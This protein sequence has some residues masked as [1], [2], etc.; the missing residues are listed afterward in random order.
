MRPLY[1]IL[2]LWCR[3]ASRLFF[4]DF[5]VIR[6]LK[7]LETAEEDDEDFGNNETSGAPTTN[8]SKDDLKRTSGPDDQQKQK[9]PN[10]AVGVGSGVSTDLRISGSGD[11][12]DE[13]L[14]NPELK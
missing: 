5:Q 2:S 12:A 14:E 8:Y 1:H 4:L 10:M 7:W 9:L 6:W 13:T 3:K 11:N